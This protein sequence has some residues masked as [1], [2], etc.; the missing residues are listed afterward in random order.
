MY[1]Y[2]TKDFSDLASGNDKAKFEG[3]EH[4]K[5]HWATPKT[6]FT[7]AGQ[8]C[9][10]KVAKDGSVHIA[11]YD[12]DAGDVRYAKL[13]SFDAAYLEANN[14]CVVDSN[15]IVGSNLTLDVALDDS[16]KAIPHIGYYG[17]IGP[18]MAYLTTE[19]AAKANAKASTGTTEDMFTGY[20]EVTEIPTP[21][22]APKD[23]INVGLWKDNDG[24]INYST[25][26]GSAPNGTNVGETSHT[27]TGT[28]SSDGTTYGN[29]SK[30][31]VIA[32]EIRPTSANG[33]METAQKQ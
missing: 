25:T 13:S 2:S 14:S 21:S 3:S 5:E 10:I 11:A 30:N 24:K 18:K 32:Y 26:D 23:R 8:Y 27:G 15:G 12:N 31:P 6:I 4:V 29:G 7:D 9:Q 33:Y 16:G 28:T 1:T 17:S 20:W 19:G 22:N